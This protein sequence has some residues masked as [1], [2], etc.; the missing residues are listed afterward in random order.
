MWVEKRRILAE[1]P[2]Q[3]F[4]NRHR[5]IAGGI[6]VAC[7]LGVAAATALPHSS[8]SLPNV[9]NIVEPL[10]IFPE[11]LPTPDLPFVHD[12]RV[13]PGDT[14]QAIFR[15]LGIEDAKALGFIM[16]HET[17]AR[18]LRQLR[19]G[20]SLT[21]V[22]DGS[23]Q[24]LSL[25][26]PLAQLG[27]QLVIQRKTLH[28]PFTVATTGKTA[29]ET[30][31]EMRSGTIRNSL[32]AATDAVDLPNSIAMQ[33]ADLFGTE[34][35]FHTDL[36]RGDQFSVIYET[37][38]DHGITTRAGRVLAAEFINRGKRHAVVLHTSADGKSQY[39]TSS[40]RSLRQSFLRSPLE[41]SR[42]TS[43]F[44]RRFHP[45]F[46]NWRD[47]RGVDLGAP[48]GTPIKATS[49]GTVTF[50]GTQR[51]YGNIIVV[52]HRNDISTAYAHL[53][54]F[55]TGLKAGSKVEQSQIIGK[56]GAT[57][58]ATSAHLHYEIRVGNVAH[59]PMTIA[60][61]RADSL[62]G[63]ELARF[64][65]NARPHLARINLLTHRTEVTGELARR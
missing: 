24:L 49:D 41:F 25:T 62:T 17:A 63:A 20:R 13:A 51:G 34:V 29:L 6:A 45:I 5:M 18:E 61:P 64:A 1:L 58:A 50:V 31:V 28:E 30:Q 54:A 65:E 33:L 35:D 53:S 39:Y 8:A 57:G 38:Y 47:H 37:H 16:Q 10:S 9:R 42:V 19:A 46:K 55:A 32:F 52:K 40:G 2:W 23:G 44:G 36:R 48:A 43:G 3:L 14:V 7:V 21:A 12:V 4:A 56:V 59:D 22:V 26:L 27:D 11:P 60:L 15:R